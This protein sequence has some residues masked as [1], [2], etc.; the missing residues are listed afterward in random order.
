MFFIGLDV[1]QQTSSYCI[2]NRHGQIVKEEKVRGDWDLL[3]TRLA[4]VPRPWTVCYEASCGYGVLHDR[5]IK[6]GAKVTV[7]HP[8]KLRL[9]FRAKNKNDRSDARKLAKLL[10]LDEV[11][12][13]WVPQSEIRQWRELVEYRRRLIAQ[14]TRAK[15]TL[16]ALLRGCGIQ[17]I[18]LRASQ[19]PPVAPSSRPVPAPPEVLPAS[20]PLPQPV[21]KRL[22]S[23]RGLAALQAL[24]LPTETA[25]L[26]R[27]LLLEE[28]EHLQTQI[29]RVDQNLDAR[30]QTHPGVAT[31]QTIPGVGPRTAEAVM[32]YV[33]DPQ[34]FQHS[35]AIGAY[36]GLV[37]CQDASAGVNRLGHITK[38][39][40][41]TLRWLLIE[42][43]WQ[44]IRRSPTLKAYYQRI[45]RHRPDRHKIALVAT[46]HYLMRVMLALAKSGQ[47]WRETVVEKNPWGAA[48]HPSPLEVP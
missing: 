47:P 4:A 27:D 26:R 13:V 46:G 42:A 9:I 25:A 2:L 22:W 24:S 20:S 6:L 7:A 14:R 23:G 28:L 17:K 45:T 43:A 34:R 48:S 10:Y 41:G 3:L 21:S 39:G 35:K 29:K 30:S 37:P 36:V 15:N 16:R 32:A 38:D 1:H 12:T 5:L 18:L 44:G 19:A 31:L 33:G 40:P 11:P 8:G